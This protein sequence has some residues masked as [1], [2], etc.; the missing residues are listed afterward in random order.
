MRY[1]EF[2]RASKI[3]RDSPKSGHPVDL[4]NSYVNVKF[5]T[6]FDE[7]INLLYSA[8]GC[9]FTRSTECS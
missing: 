7:Q 8:L 5:V 3:T 6:H 1:S 9:E 2:T 4:E